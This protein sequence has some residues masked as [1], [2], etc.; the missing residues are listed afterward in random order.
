MRRHLRLFGIVLLV[1]PALSAQRAA[2]PG[3]GTGTPA[4]GAPA[5]PDTPGS[6][7]D[8]CVD[9]Y[10]YACSAWQTANPIPPDRVAWGR[11]NELQ[12]RGEIIVRD[13]LEQAA[14]ERPGRTANEQKIGDYY[15]ACMDETAIEQ[16]GTAPLARDVARISALP[17]RAA[18]P[19]EIARL[20]LQGVQA[21]F[22]FGAG[23]DYKD[24]RQM[25]AELDAGGLGLPDRDYYV[26]D[27]ARSVDLRRQYVAHVGRMFELLG[28]A[29]ATAAAEAG[30]VMAI[31]TSLAAKALDQTARRDPQRVYHRLTRRELAALGPAF[32]WTRYFQEIG[33]PAFESLNVVEPDF[34]AGLN[35]QIEVTPLDE[36]KTYLRWQLLHARAPLLSAAFV[37]EDFA[38]FGTTLRG[39]REL[40]PRW[41]R[42]VTAASAD[43]G[44]AIGQH[45]VR[46]TFGEQG[47]TRTLALVVALEAAL[48]ADIAELPWMGQ[49]TKQAALLKLRAITNRIG[50][51]DRWRDY[52]AIDIVRTDAA[53]NARRAKAWE[54][55]RRIGTIGRARDPKDWPYPPMTIN[56]SY[57]PRENV[58]TFPAGI[59]Q[60]P[61]FDNEADDASTFGGIGAVIGHELTH[62]F[63]DQG[64]QF[65]ADGNL[66][67]WWTPEDRQRF[68]AR[69]RCLEEQYGHFV[70]V[71]ALTLNGKLTL[72]EN[73]A[74]NGGLRM[75]Y[76]AMLARFAGKEPP[77]VEGRTAR[78]RFFLG[79]AHVWCENRTDAI[80]RKATAMDPH[81]PGRYRVNGPVSN[82][83]EFREAFGCAGAAP[84]V[85]QH[86]CRVW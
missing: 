44:E 20:Q 80:A 42:C 30:V 85:N 75:A 55:Q 2:D 15:A 59:L 37:N 39:A 5:S 25:I 49:E 27:D 11:F 16:A 3:V 40:S 54:L 84:M 34:I 82:M 74:D 56:A 68:D 73:I 60:P 67:D 29:P 76:L 31:E 61:I 86:A 81:A 52:A 33:A 62:G 10:A 70:T 7:L 6:H 48:A 24:A 57:E 28:D 77:P 26:K 9:F 79:W 12:Q 17:S 69:A 83:P 14:V 46:Q 23:A 41:K 19:I 53:G 47:K 63:D 8:P 50:Y 58:I 35:R 21:L 4:A 66:R 32:D 13:I 65:D 22:T 72:G 45:H 36:W 43:L 1:A 51:P 38:F 18:L 78:Q 64:S 71:D